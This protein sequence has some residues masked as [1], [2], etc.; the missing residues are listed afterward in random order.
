MTPNRIPFL[1]STTTALALAALL[2]GCAV[3][4]TYERPAIASP[5]AWKE[6]PAAEGWLPAAPAD[7]LDRGE[8]WQL[9]NDAG[10]N[11][12]AARVQ[13]SNQNIAA[14]VAS[15]AQATA[16]VRE[17]R[18]GL[19]PTVGLSGSAGRSGDRT[20]GTSSG[21]SSVGLNVDWA[22]D[23]W[24]RLRAAVG[25]AQASAQASAADL[26]AARLSA[27]GELAINYFS[28]R[29][30]DAELALLA[31]TIEGYE[32][33]YTIARNRY[34]AGIAA[35]SDVL[36]AQTQLVNTRA[37]RVALERTRATLEHAIAVLVGA[38]P[39]DFKLPPLAAWTPAVPAVPLGVPSTLLQRRPDIAAAERAVAVANAQIGIE[40]SAYFPSLNL[41]GSLSRSAS[42]VQ[43][44]F[45]A[46]N[47]LW[48]LGLSAAQVLFDAGAIGARVDSAKA[49]HEAAVARYR[50]TVLTAF[51]GVEDQLTATASLAQQ[52]ALR[53]EASVAADK[54]EQQL[55][56]RYRAGQVS[57]TE[58]VTAQASAL[59]ARRTVLQLGVNR[60]VAAVGLIQG[61]GG[62]WDAAWLKDATPG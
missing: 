11:E 12:L 59:N 9:F 7:A 26:A 54:T 50:Q 42:R 15:Y 24:G 34:D 48:S 56:N 18:A 10:L 21:S 5:S 44:L 20:A 43:D 37:E 31:D 30:A 53:R 4:P 60:Q 19:F 32:R 27:H 47:T 14:A 29:E 52:E 33:S 35:Q 16:L 62:G 22:P 36:Q 2:A 8:W 51:Q 46:S 58:V 39:A 28:L 45:S 3:G 57:Y 13:V 41:S 25:S 1:R 38:A 23:V 6:A 40:R 17:Q 61:L 55:L 49:G